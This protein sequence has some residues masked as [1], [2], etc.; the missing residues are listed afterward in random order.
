MKALGTHD[1]Q[2]LA[3]GLDLRGYPGGTAGLAQE[4]R[5]WIAASGRDGITSYRDALEL[6]DPEVLHALS[7]NVD[8]GICGWLLAGG[9][10]APRGAGQ[11]LVALVD[12]A[13]RP[14]R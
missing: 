11:D 1:M 5:Q 12:Y 2:L 4:A 8:G 6:T 10:P 9:N 13:V 3:Q 7:D 14:G